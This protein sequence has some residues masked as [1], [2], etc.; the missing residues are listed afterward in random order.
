MKTN[1]VP[2][3]WT[4]LSCSTTFNWYAGCSSTICSHD[5]MAAFVSDRNGILYKV[6]WYTYIS[7][8]HK[9]KVICG[10]GGCQKF[11]GYYSLENKIFFLL[12][13]RST[14]YLA[15]Q[16]ICW[17]KPKVAG[18]KAIGGSCQKWLPP[19]ESEILNLIHTCVKATALFFFACCKRSSPRPVATQNC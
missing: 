3:K 7:E 9:H 15:F 5:V 11:Q 17:T 19:T 18:P 1:S 8:P 14:K 4:S 10:W 16:H 6:L 13:I 12:D 2:L